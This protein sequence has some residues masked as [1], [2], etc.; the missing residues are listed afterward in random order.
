MTEYEEEVRACL[1]RAMEEAP[2]GKQRRVVP[3]LAAELERIEEEEA[4]FPDFP[5]W[6]MRDA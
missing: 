6:D 5:D 1:R 4:E 3:M 2:S